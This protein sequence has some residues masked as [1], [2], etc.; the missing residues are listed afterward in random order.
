[1]LVAASI[2]GSLGRKRRCRGGICGAPV[3][4]ADVV[5]GGWAIRTPARPRPGTSVA[6]PGCGAPAAAGSLCGTC[7][8]LA[9]APGFAQL[10]GLPPLVERAGQAV[11]RG[12][13]R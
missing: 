2:A 8:R 10:A 4:A 7:L 13:G 9:F 6:C 3:L 12:E 1:M 5:G 11:G